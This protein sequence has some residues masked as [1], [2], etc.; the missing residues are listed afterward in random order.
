L[1]LPEIT[2][3]TSDGIP[4]Y[5][6]TAESDV[7]ILSDAEDLV[8][9]LTLVDEVWEPIVTDRQLYGSTYTVK[10]YRPRT[11]GL[12]ARIEQWKSDDDG[13]VHWRVITKDNLTSIYGLTGNPYFGLPVSG[14]CI[15]VAALSHL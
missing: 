14:S 15:L 12:F 8:P 10:R 7:F 2:R 1:S 3:K 13:T 6:D 5:N 9:E 11:E 4:L